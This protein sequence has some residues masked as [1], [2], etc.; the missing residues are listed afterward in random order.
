[1]H[2]DG[3]SASYP[4]LAVCGRSRFCEGGMLGRNLIACGVP[5]T[6]GEDLKDPVGLGPRSEC[7]LDVRQS[8]SGCVIFGSALSEEGTGHVSPSEQG[9]S[10]WGRDHQENLNPGPGSSPMRANPQEK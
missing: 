8:C 5:G 6:M 4:S 7:E 2:S 10:S 3:V 1:M 9:K